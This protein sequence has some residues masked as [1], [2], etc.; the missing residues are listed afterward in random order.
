MGDHKVV[1][2]V[3]NSPTPATVA[4][5]INVTRSP[6]SREILAAVV[7]NQMFDGNEYAMHGE[8][9]DTLFEVRPRRCRGAG[10]SPP[11][12]PTPVDR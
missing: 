5:A 7:A 1:T 6:Y 10:N 9:P 2:F 4:S 11:A 8:S 12:P 3:P